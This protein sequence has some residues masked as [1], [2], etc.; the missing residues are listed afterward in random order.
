MRLLG[1]QGRKHAGGY[2]L[3]FVFMIL[4]AA[5]TAASAWMMREVINRVFVER[6]AA[7]LW[8]VAVVLVVIY[9]VKGFA[10]YAEDVTLAKIGNR[11]VASIQMLLFHH[12]LQ[13]DVAYFSS[14]HSTEFIA[15]QSFMANAARNALGTMITAVGR[16]ALTLVGLLS[17]M[18]VQDPS[19]T[20]AGLIFMPAALIGVRYLIRRSRK[21]MES[22]F[23]SYSQIMATTQ[24]AAQG[25]R[26]VKSFNLGPLLIDR[27]DTAVRAF[28]RASNRLVMVS[29]R[30]SPMMETLGGITVSGV[31]LYA[32]WC[33]IHLNQ[34]P[35]TFFSFLT[36]FLLAYEPAKRLAK[37]NI[38]LGAALV[39]VRML[40]VILDMPLREPDADP[41]PNLV[42]K[43]GK[44]VMRNVTFT[45]RPGE[46]VLS[47]FS[48]VAEPGKKTALI[49]P[50]GSGKSTVFNLLQGFYPYAEGSIEIDGQEVR[51]V[52]LASLREAIAVVSQ[53]AFLFRGTIRENIAYGRRDAS[54]AE[55]QAAA[56]A[57][58]AHDFIVG[59][60]G[61]YDAKVGEHGNALSGGQR[62]RIA[63]A[64][65]ILKGAPIILLD[66]ATSALDT[67]SEQHVQAGIANLSVGRTMIL[68]AHR[69]ESY[70]HVDHVVRIADG[71]AEPKALLRAVPD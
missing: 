51:S 41:R 10:G 33:V 7:A 32:G 15:Q 11:I 34:S 64:R 17:V 20:L 56:E 54:E 16:D 45:Y 21:I 13:Q 57:A 26:I 1:E 60:A 71:M 63:I 46:P 49:G 18:L 70:A 24:E 4:S 38:D 8:V 29:S 66:E 59:F 55:I 35:G 2:A 12:S 27:M 22:E 42:V 68:I 40:Y 28:E 19:M 62:Q 9:V 61:G 6:D 69:A 36:A 37:F 30:S 23:T 50:S 53:D 52:N 48:F 5:A 43:A 44:I 31:I 65:A 67:S 25:I 58:H 14:R 39:G 47:K 3:A